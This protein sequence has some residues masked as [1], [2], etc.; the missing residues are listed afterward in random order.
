MAD[1]A[2]KTKDRWDKI[3]VMLKP[4]GGL[5]T[6][7]AVAL[8]GFL[9]SNLLEQRQALEM[10]TRLYTELM[11][12]RE[13]AESALRKDMFG[14]IIQ[15]F[16]DPGKASLDE[17][18][19]NLELLAYNFHES[20]NLKPLFIYLHRQV[21]MGKDPRLTEYQRRLE[22]VA[23]EITQKQ[24]TV[25]EG[26]GESFSVAV[27]LNEL[28]K[29]PDGLELDSQTLTVEGIERHFRIYA[30]QLDP[31]AREVQVRVVVETPRARD[32]EERRYVAEF[33]V[34]F[35][36][37]PMID[38]TRLLPDQR[39]GVV[40]NSLNIEQGMAVLTLAYFPGSYAA[41]KEKPYIQEVMG[42]LLDNG[43][44]E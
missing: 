18:V 1:Q 3:D 10:R 2:A 16:F 37:F 35:F 5:L 34:G 15:S 9:G 13:E 44:K 30:V 20:L 38:N 29:A 11:S 43:L 33:R 42:R 41:L 39:F 27:P 28:A 25:I 24:L 14:T 22:R 40:L 23:R 4:L 31:V 7:V 36:D 19:L 6:A 12:K 8:V 21:V 17:R 26:A 32:A